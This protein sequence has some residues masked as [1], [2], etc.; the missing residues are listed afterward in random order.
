MQTL[1]VLLSHPSDLTPEEHEAICQALTDY[2]IQLGKHTGYHL[3][4]LF[5]KENAFSQ[6]GKR[7]QQG[8]NHQLV[9]R[10]H[11]V[12]SI[13][14]HRLGSPTLVHESGT[15]EEID[16]ARRQ[17]KHIFLHYSS[18]EPDT[19]GLPPETRR[20]IQQEYSR[21]SDFLKRISG[22]ALGMSFGSAAE[23]RT[24]VLQDLQNFHSHMEDYLDELNHRGD[25]SPHVPTSTDP[26][27]SLNP[28]AVTIN[29]SGC[30]TSSPIL[31][32]SPV[33]LNSGASIARNPIDCQLNSEVEKKK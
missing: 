14:K 3:T 21:L 4:P 28:N 23:L 17:R 1:E 27:D 10:C 32:N 24:H 26:S 8:L 31:V 12:V 9:D 22:F 15:V 30:I 20:K 2:N 5:W 11:M 18:Q 7:P 16:E 19:V 29:N 33:M 25:M 6:F 13:F